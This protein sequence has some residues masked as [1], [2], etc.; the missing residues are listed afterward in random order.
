MKS[1]D[2]SL[3][4][5]ASCTPLS[6]RE[7]SSVLLASV[8]LTSSTALTWKHLSYTWRS[9]SLNALSPTESTSG[10]PCKRC[11]APS[12]TVVRSLRKWIATSSSLTVTY[13]SVRRFSEATS[14][15]TS[16]TYKLPRT[17]MELITTSLISPTTPASCSTST[18]C[19]ITITL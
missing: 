5:L 13:G 4:P 19:L 16:R 1:G 14:S 8:C 10:K 2:P 9:T 15:S 12:S 18:L 7:R 11:A 6:R 17:L 3:T